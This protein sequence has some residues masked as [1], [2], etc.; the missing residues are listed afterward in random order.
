MPYYVDLT[1]NIMII[2]TIKIKSLKC[3]N[4]LIVERYGQKIKEYKANIRIK[5]PDPRICK[6]GL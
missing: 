3:K 2:W 5:I 4:N 6:L 1:K